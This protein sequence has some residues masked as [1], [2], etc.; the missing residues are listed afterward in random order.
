MAQF[1]R[2]EVYQKLHNHPIVPLLSATNVDDALLILDA[3]YQGGVRVFELTNRGDFAQEIFI[4]IVKYIRQHYSDLA[5]GIG[6]IL[7]AG[8]ASLYIQN[9]ADFIICP[10]LVEEVAK[11]C[12]RRKIAWIPGVATLS[13]ISKAE[14]LGAEIVKLFPAQ[15]LG[16]SFVKAL[17]GPMPHTSVMA[18]GGVELTE[19]SLSAW[20]EAGVTCVGVGGQL[21]SKELLATRNFGLL[22][23]QIREGFKVAEKYQRK[24]QFSL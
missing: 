9:G 6:T 15:V 23:N 8:T 12:N 3:C 14:E 2:L 24:Q 20:F 16:T 4:E 1:T 13:E 22:T 21:F 7:D 19:A 18:T 10:N 17:K 11:V 5:F